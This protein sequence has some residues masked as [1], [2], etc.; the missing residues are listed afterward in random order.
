MKQNIFVAFNQT[1]SNISVKSNSFVAYSKYT[2]VAIENE[3][4]ILA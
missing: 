3:K 4:S 1:D 2:H